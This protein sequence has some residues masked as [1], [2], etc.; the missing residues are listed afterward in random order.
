[1]KNNSERK[2]A[3]MLLTNPQNQKRATTR[4]DSRQD[5]QSDCDESDFQEVI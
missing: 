4:I 5:E 3:H 1:M 2:P